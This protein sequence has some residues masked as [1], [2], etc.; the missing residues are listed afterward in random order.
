MKLSV[1]VEGEEKLE[2]ALTGVMGD[3]KTPI[4]D[5]ERPLSDEVLLMVRD[6]FRSHGAR[7]RS[8]AWPANKASTIA[9]YTAQNRRGFSVLN[10]PMRR[11]GALYAAVTTRGAPH[12]I[13]EVTDDSMTHGTDLIYA[14]VHQRKRR[15]VYDP[16]DEDARKFLA[17]IR[18]GL[19]QKFKDRGFDYVDRGEIPF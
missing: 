4:R 10:E 7:G 17:V 6:Q 12:G 18:R 11:T 1:G 3:L 16:T 8:G 19:G 2:R 5:V 14:G 9:G 15:K 13:F